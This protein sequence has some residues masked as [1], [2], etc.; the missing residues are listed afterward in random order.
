MA[1][2]NVGNPKFYIDM[3]SFFKASG[4]IESVKANTGDVDIRD[5]MSKIIGLNPTDYIRTGDAYFGTNDDGS[6]YWYYINVNLKQGYRASGEGKAFIAWLNHNFNGTDS[7]QISKPKFKLIDATTDPVTVQR[8]YEAPDEVQNFPYANGEDSFVCNGFS[9]G[10][11]NASDVIFNQIRFYLNK[12]SVP[13]TGFD[14]TIGSLAWGEI[15]E[16][17]HSPDLQLTMT[18]EFDGIETQ[19]TKGGNTLTQINYATAPSWAVYPAWQLST[20]NLNY[21]INNNYKE[22][23]QASRGRRIWD[24][25]FSYVDSKDLFSVNESMSTY[26]ISEA[27]VNSDYESGTFN[28][29]GNFEEENTAYSDDSF[30]NKVMSRTKGGALPFIFQ[31]DGNNNS[32]D[33]F[34]ICQFDQDSFQ[35]K[36]VAHNVYDI[37]LKIREVW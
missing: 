24:L 20:S 11:V 2:A 21:H 25:K 33:Q 13:E 36:Q 22:N 9:I 1:R 29:N 14:L 8:S 28:A 32:P 18:R 10:E 23:R 19:Q 7:H 3:L 35:F 34:A 30:M 37:S 27:D 12:N 16:M 26:N 6:Y 15:F 5:D 17:P 31:P 4:L